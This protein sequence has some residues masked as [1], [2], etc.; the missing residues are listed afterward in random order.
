MLSLMMISGRVTGFMRELMLA[1]TFGAS[2]EADLAI[3][4]L[5]LPDIFTGLLL[6]GGLNAALVPAFKQLEPKVGAKL[7]VQIV[8]GIIFIFSAFA[9]VIFL[10]PAIIVNLVA[11]GLAPLY[12]HGRTAVWL[13]VGLAIVATAATGV[14]SAML[15]SQNRFGVAGAGTLIFN[16]TMMI[17]LIFCTPNV[18]KVDVFA[19]FVLIAC[20]I[21]LVSQLVSLRTIP[22]SNAFSKNLISKNL[23]F[24]FFGAFSATSLIVLVPAVVR[25][26]GSLMGPGSL[27]TINYATKLVELPL[28]IVITTISIVALPALADYYSGNNSAAMGR[29]F[30]TG[31]RRGVIFAVAIGLPMAAFSVEI[32][33]GIFSLSGLSAD[34]VGQIARIFQVLT[35]TLPLI[36]ISSMQGVLLNA[37]ARTRRFFVAIAAAFA[38]FILF[39]MAAYAAQSFFMVV[40]SMVVFHL[41]A[42]V[43]LRVA[44]G[45]PMF[46]L[47]QTNAV[48]LVQGVAVSLTTIAI[49]KFALQ[50]ME[51]DAF[52][53]SAVIAGFSVLISFFFSL[54]ALNRVKENI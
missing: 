37:S 36:A 21:R 28:G 17:G 53:K 54:W 43:F 51:D 20:L 18:V 48:L 15:N 33:T 16:T 5:T 4:L 50:F 39:L 47:S 11:P 12:A 45:E 9:F 8:I 22:V 14:T 31:L 27:A 6:A 7:F 30:R 13:C 26:V 40:F 24:A 1:R 41:S 35:L 32:V 10:W 3:V 29:A 23:I 25:S 52:V 19:L 42:C 38:C 44:S 34:V 2:I 49:A 46:T